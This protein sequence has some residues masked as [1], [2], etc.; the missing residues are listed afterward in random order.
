MGEKLRTIHKKDIY[1]LAGKLNYR[2][3]LSVDINHLLPASGN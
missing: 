1:F 3:E 2:K